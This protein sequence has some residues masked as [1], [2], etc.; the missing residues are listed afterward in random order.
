MI[1]LWTAAGRPFPHGPLTEATSFPSGEKATAKHWVLC[2]FRSAIRFPF[3]ASQI[4]MSGSQLA[5]AMSL[6][7]GGVIRA[8]Y[9]IRVVFEGKDLLSGLGIPKNSMGRKKS[10]D[11]CRTSVQINS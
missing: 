4:L 11:P 5:V 2:P 7:F 6:P 1:S 8:M 10:S 3:S 9:H